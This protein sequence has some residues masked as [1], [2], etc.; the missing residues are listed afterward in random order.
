VK[1]PAH[2]DWWRDEPGGRAW[3]ESLPRLVAELAEAWGL[4][5][6][7]PLTGGNVSLVLR[8]S[9][10]GGPAVLKLN[11]PE[12]DSEHEAAALEVWDGRGAVRVL[13]HDP[14]RG[15]LL[16][17]W[18][19]PGDMLWGIE[20]D[21]AATTIAA[22]V[23]REL[24]RDVEDGAPFVALSAAAARWAVELPRDWDAVGRPFARDVLDEA[25]ATCRELGAEPVPPMLLHQDLQGSNVL[26]SERGWLA[27]DPKP[28]AGDP[29]FDAASLLRDRRW[30]L[31]RGGEAQRIG[32]R[33]D[34]LAEQLELDRERLRRWG[35]VHALAWGLSGAGVERDMIR[36]A[37]LL[38]RA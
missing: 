13:A 24:R 37:E 10:D 2:L 26:R 28:L 25:V 38:H 22:G 7:E 32:R 31:G 29:A 8:V 19:D 6:A 11:F 16:V 14:E 12:P 15:A 5:A 1:L 30:L 36:C 23:L 18:C 4:V 27:I 17:E 34:V 20:D 21:E 35:V 33:L 9:R 3:L